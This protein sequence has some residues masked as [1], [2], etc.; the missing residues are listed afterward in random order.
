MGWNVE[1]YTAF[2]RPQWYT[3]SEKALFFGAGVGSPS[4]GG[5]P[6][7]PL[8]VLMG[9]LLKGWLLTSWTGR[10]NALS[11]QGLQSHD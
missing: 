4:E 3:N 8:C 6:L 9:S 10:G 2:L 11:M 5:F 1:L 7:S